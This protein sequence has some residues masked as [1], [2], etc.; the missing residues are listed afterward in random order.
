M[1]SR[2]PLKVGTKVVA[3]CNFGPIEE[4]QPGIITGT[5]EYSF[6]WRFRSMYLCTFAGNVKAAAK[7]K[8]IE[9]FHHGCSLGMLEDPN[10]VGQIGLARRNR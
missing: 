5:A 3:V 10:V 9:D 7:P 6:F 1:S 8:E 4:G 2:L